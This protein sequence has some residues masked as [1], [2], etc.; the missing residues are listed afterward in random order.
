MQKCVIVNEKKNGNSQK[1]VPENYDSF[2]AIKLV[3]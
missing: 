1:C 3:F 2:S